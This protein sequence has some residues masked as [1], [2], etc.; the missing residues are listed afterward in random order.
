MYRLPL[1]QW[2]NKGVE[3]LLNKYGHVIDA[4]STS[5]REIINALKDG[6]NIVP[7]WLLILIVMIV[8]WRARGW[9]LALGSGLG[10]LLIYDM[11]L[12]PAFLETL[13]LVIISAIISIAIGIPIGI[14]IARNNAINRIFTPLL[15]VMQTMPSFVYLIPALMFFG[16]G[17][18]PA[19]FATVVFA[20]PPAIRLTD[21]GIR[22]VP[23]DL[24]EVGEA[25]GST[26]SQMLWKIQLPLA[27]PTI[28]AGINQTMMLS[29]SMV[30]VAGMIGAGGFGS[31]VLEG[32][33]QMDIGKGFE[34]GLGVVILAMV[35]DRICQ[36]FS[37]TARI[38]KK[39]P[40]KKTFKKS[41][42]N[43]V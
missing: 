1:G 14:I 41:F 24:V 10:L 39:Q 27:M 31:G 37:Q 30:V 34:N 38:N 11:L 36:G 25:F 3:W 23:K 17:T 42:N 5:I 8:A 35:L 29:L 16:L 43:T 9:R 40:V 28:M 12:W 33:S 21:L 4:F 20:M 26:P 22:Q 7:W 2:V 13:V 6:L 18:V 15:D 19:I 32:I